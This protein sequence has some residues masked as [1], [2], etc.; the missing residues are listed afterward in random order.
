MLSCIQCNAHYGMKERGG[1]F[2]FVG[3]IPMCAINSLYIAVFVLFYRQLMRKCFKFRCSCNVFV[4]VCCFRFW[5]QNWNFSSLSLLFWTKYDQLTNQHY[6][7]WWVKSINILTWNNR[8]ASVVPSWLP[9]GAAAASVS[10][11]QSL[12]GCL[13][14]VYHRQVSSFFLEAVSYSSVKHTRTLYR[15]SCW[16]DEKAVISVKVFLSFFGLISLVT[17]KVNTRGCYHCI[18]AV[19]TEWTF[20]WNII[21]SFLLSISF[22]FSFMS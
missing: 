10:V 16:L 12:A 22:H 21:G 7:R 19:P 2:K 5:W 11:R 1:G 17:L 20:P 14:N 13:D 3:K 4:F 9:R 6:Y 18:D 8:K 15:T